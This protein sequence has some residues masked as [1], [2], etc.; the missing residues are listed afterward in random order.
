VRDALVVA[1]V[2]VAFVLA[3]GA[4]AVI[5]EVARLRQVP[6]GMITEHVRSLHL[7]PRAPAADY[8]AI[9]SRVSGLPGV[10]AAGLTQ[11]V[12][13]QNWG[14]EADFT[15]RGRPREGRPIAGLRYVTP[16]YFRTL[17]IPILRGRSFTEG[18]AATAPRVV[19]V[20]DA[21]A[22]RYFPGEDPVG[23]DL[24]RGTIVGVAGDVRQAGLQRPA[25][26]EIY[27]PAAQNVTMASDIGMSLVVRTAGGVETRTA[28]PFARLR[29]AVR[30]D[31]L[32]DLIRATVRDVNPSLAIF[33]VRDM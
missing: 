31:P 3:C 6:T 24:D 14:W 18:D 13:L 15:V 28:N 32:V 9:E 25:D 10:A 2:A 23:R 19:I 33:N 5:T 12:P 7:T 20:N 1:E 11:L 27:Y 21:L 30:P 17:G 4:A 29:S 22:R 16:G 8:Y 26:P